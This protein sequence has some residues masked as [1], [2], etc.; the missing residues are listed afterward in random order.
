MAI[1]V[2]SFAARE[3]WNTN[4]VLLSL[5][6]NK[7]TQQRAKDLAFSHKSIYL[8]SS[9]LVRYMDIV[10][11]AFDF[12]DNVRFL[13]MTSICLNESELKVIGENV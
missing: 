9:G 8:S 1:Q 5:W 11:D 12:V 6:K 4:S 10:G 2:S 3:E 13:Q 7:L